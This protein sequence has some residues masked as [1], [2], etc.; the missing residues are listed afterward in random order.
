MSVVNDMLKD[1]ERRRADADQTADLEGLVAAAPPMH[2]RLQALK[3]AALGGA[4][5]LAAAGVWQWMDTQ[6]AA[7]ISTATTVAVAPPGAAG[8][9]HARH[10][11]APAPQASA[12]PQ[13]PVRDG[14]QQVGTAGPTPKDVAKGPAAALLHAGPAFPHTLPADA[15]L[16]PAKVAPAAPARHMPARPSGA[17]SRQA[18]AG[19]H[20]QERAKA[21]HTPASGSDRK[22]VRS[23]RQAR[24]GMTKQMLPLSPHDRA[25]QL[26][27]KA[28]Q[29][30]QRGDL[31]SAETL[32]RRALKVAPRNRQAR[33]SLA[34]LLLQQKRRTEAAALL[35]A[36]LRSQPGDPD[37]ARLYGRLLAGEGHTKQAVMVMEKALPA[38]GD[39]PTFHALL[40][41]LYQRLGRNGKAAAQYRSALS[42]VP[43]EAVWWMGLG[44]S[45]ENLHADRQAAAAYRQALALPGLDNRLRDY[46]TGR[47]QAVGESQDRQQVTP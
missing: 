18:H 10:P 28:M 11:V 16:A 15:G 43:T 8:A 7:N 20:A 5:A 32:L 27:G 22:A 40:A 44:I 2:E 21:A 33:A 34:A 12:R 3:W 35:V 6:H 1:L 38:A 4:V 24:D 23:H 36:G 14:K 26:C 31:M 29:R 41:A 46:V 13:P 39:D 42:S 9:T 17:S 25:R 19:A 37:Y 47:L 30:L 45:L